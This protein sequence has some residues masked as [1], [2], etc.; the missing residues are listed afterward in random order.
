MIAQTKEE[1]EVF[2]KYL[3]TIYQEFIV[4]EYVGTPDSEYT[5]GVLNTMDGEFIN[6]IAVHK[7][8][9]TA[10]NNRIKIKNRTG[11]EKLGKREI[12]AIGRKVPKAY[13][14]WTSLEYPIN[15]QYTKQWCLFKH[16]D[17]SYD[18]E[19]HKQMANLRAG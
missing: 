8:I 16:L 19:F 1:I 7:S 12:S 10:L 4:Q 15:I 9:E 14:G 5:V 17:Q 11:I 3:L 2:C 6:S 13:F 18:T